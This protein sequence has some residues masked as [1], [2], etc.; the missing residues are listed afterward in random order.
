MADLNDIQTSVK[1][2]ELD[3][4]IGQKKASFSEPF[5]RLRRSLLAAQVITMWFLASLCS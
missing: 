1:V 5:A 2:A 4:A 3:Q